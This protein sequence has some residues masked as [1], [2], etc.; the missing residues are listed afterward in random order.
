MDIE[1][2]Q[3]RESE[4]QTLIVWAH[5][6]GAE[7]RPTRDGRT[8]WV[9][10][11]IKLIWARHATNAGAWTHWIPSITV[12]GPKVHTDGSTHGNY[13]DLVD[14]ADPEWS[15]WVADLRPEQRID[16]EVTPSGAI[17]PTR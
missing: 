15:Q 8:N 13:V 2:T 4:T 1:I 10:E 14:L 3:R 7:I 6:R 17:R 12:S 5:V 11:K 16:G 9:P